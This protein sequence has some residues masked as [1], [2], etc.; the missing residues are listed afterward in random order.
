MQA[1]LTFLIY[2]CEED[3]SKSVAHCLE[4]DVVAVGN[5]KAEAVELLKEL[6]ED[7]FSAASE[8][9]TLDR[10]FNPAPRRYWRMLAQ[11]KPYRPPRWLHERRIGSRRIAR[12]RYGQTCDPVPAR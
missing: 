4:T 5:T 1:E 3:P 10:V 12:V 6:I 9:G 7:L 8:D 11:A 2:P